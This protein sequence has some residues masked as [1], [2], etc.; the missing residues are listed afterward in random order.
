MTEAEARGREGM[1]FGDAE[2]LALK[3]EE[4]AMFPGRYIA[5]LGKGKGMNS[6][7]GAPEGILPTLLIFCPPEM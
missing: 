1:R 2:F 3:I 4:G 6:P 5:S 7:L